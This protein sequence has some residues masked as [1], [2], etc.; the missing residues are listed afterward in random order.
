MKCKICGS[1]N[2]DIVYNGEIRDG[3]VGNFTKQ[4]VPIYKCKDCDVTWH[5]NI[6]K[7]IDSFYESAEYR[8]AV[9]DGSE[10]AHFYELHDGGVY[11]TLRYTGT[12]IFRDKVVADI[13]CAAGA[14]LDFVKGSAKTVIGIEPSAIFRKSMQEKGFV[15][16]P[17]AKDA[18]KVYADKVNVV[19]SFDVIEHV[20][21]PEEFLRDA[22]DLLGEG[23]WQSSVRRQTHLSPV[24]L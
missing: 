19:T 11:D 9:D 13:G 20:E 21:E 16:F 10:A 23:V 12:K 6:L 4:A 22:Y 18:K 3:K 2:V 24:N 17:Y 8:N 15:T 14:F 1:A 5:D 7:D